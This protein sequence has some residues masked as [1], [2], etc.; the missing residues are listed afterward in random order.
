MIEASKAAELSSQPTKRGRRAWLIGLL[1][2]VALITIVLLANAPK[3][4]PVKVWFVRATNE[5]G[6]K[7]LVFE[8]TNG[9]RT[10]ISATAW[11]AAAGGS[12]SNTASR[13]TNREEVTNRIVAAG[14]GFDFS[15][16]APTKNVPYIVVWYFYDD[17]PFQTRG[18]RFRFRANTLFRAIG[19]P[20][21]AERLFSTTHRHI[22]PSTEIKE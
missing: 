5:G 12:G 3:P 17:P 16:E 21:L 9:M 6:V 14:T 18:Q 11:L 10:G 8:G 7:R 1:C 19:M 20:R 4:E 13:F 22:V 15:L 2:V